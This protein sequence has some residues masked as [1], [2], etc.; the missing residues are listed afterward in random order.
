[1]N[2]TERS[3]IKR[4]PARI[5]LNP[6]LR[7][8]SFHHLPVCVRETPLNFTGHPYMSRNVPF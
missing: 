2:A 8:T 1:M 6:F 5:T 3:G 7:K 4:R